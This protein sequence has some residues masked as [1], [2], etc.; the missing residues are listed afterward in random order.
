MTRVLLIL[1][2]LAGGCNNLDFA[3][4]LDMCES[5]GGRVQLYSER[6]GC[7]CEYPKDREICEGWTFRESGR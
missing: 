5:G 1:L 4:C 2:L 6:D 7:F 3:N